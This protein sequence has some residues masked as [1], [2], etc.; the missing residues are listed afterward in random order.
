MLMDLVCSSC[1]ELMEDAVK[2]NMRIRVLASDATKLPERVQTAIRKTEDRTR[3]C[4]GVLFN[5]CLSYGAR[6]EIANAC[7]QI[8][9]EVASGVTTLDTVDESAVERHLLTKGLP[10]P[11]LLIRT[12]GEK[13]VSNFLLFQ[14]AYTELFFVDKL[15]PDI[16]REDVLGIFEA[17]KTRER[18]FGC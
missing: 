15:W 11:D 16:T 6:Q 7:R 5:I 1:T 2:K 3:H 9:V 12:S 8:A 13:R 4:T 18:R 14:M 17:Y 10:D